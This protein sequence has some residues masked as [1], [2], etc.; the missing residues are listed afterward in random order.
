MDF[1][2]LFA[3]L[4]SALVGPLPPVFLL[5][6]CANL[7]LSGWTSGVA[8]QYPRGAM[9]DHARRLARQSSLSFCAVT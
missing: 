4:P 3:N 1:D 2:Y 7:S 6:S 5:L 8:A 9:A